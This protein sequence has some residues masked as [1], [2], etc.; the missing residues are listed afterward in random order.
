MYSLQTELIRRND[1]KTGAKYKLAIR[2]SLGGQY[3][4]T[5]EYD[6]ADE[7]LKA[8]ASFVRKGTVESTADEPLPEGA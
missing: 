7:C 3:E 8:F 6:S 1:E 4:L 5:K 2:T